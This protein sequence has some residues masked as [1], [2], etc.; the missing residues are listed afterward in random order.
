[1]GFKG[2]A[3]CPRGSIHLTISMGVFLNRVINYVLFIVVEDLFNYNVIFGHPWVNI[4][5]AVSPPLHI[6]VKSPTPNG[7]EKE[8]GN[9][10]EAWECYILSTYGATAPVLTINHQP[11]PETS[12]YLKPQ[13]EGPKIENKKEKF[14]KGSKIEAH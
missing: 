13:K 1:M 5:T 9:I 8:M 3:V 7:I 14:L 10:R 6:R 12:D 11:H 2:N 4:F